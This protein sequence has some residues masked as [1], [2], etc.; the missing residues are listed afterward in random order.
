[1]IPKARAFVTPAREAAH[2]AVETALLGAGFVQA[3][4]AGWRWPPRTPRQEPAFAR[5]IAMGAIRHVIAI[6]TL[7]QRVGEYDPRRVPPDL[8]SILLVAGFQLLWLPS[9]PVFAAVDQAVAAAHRRRGPKAAGMLNALLRRLSDAIDVRHG[10][11]T[12]GNSRALRTDWNAAC[13]FR[14]DVLPTPDEQDGVP[15]LAASSGERA[16][17]VAA[18]IQRHGRPATEAVLWAQQARPPVFLHRNPRRCDHRAFAAAARE[19]Q[20]LSPDMAVY[21][22]GASWAAAELAATGGAYVQDPTARE[23]ALFLQPVAG[24]RVLDLCAAPGGKSFAL[25]L[26]GCAHV[27]ACDLD[28]Q[29]LSQLRVTA[30]RM[31]LP[32]IAPLQLSGNDSRILPTDVDAALVD[33]PCSNSGVFARRPEAR[34]GLT[35][36]KLTAL[37]GLQHHLLGLGAGCVRPGGRLVYSTCS[38]EPQENE[39]LVRQWLNT[40]AGWEIAAERLSLPTAG[41]S[42]ADWRDGGYCVRLVRVR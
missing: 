8:R 11:W 33:A 1:M 18:L 7:L 26:A 22:A 4:L 27:T 13:T 12:Q 39:E 38:I 2:Q 9:V 6:E 32:E 14:R 37:V 16:S 34:L 42:A 31:Q 24:E 20:L 29:R 10:A 3:V 35:R 36:E 5:E 23:A 40:N 30:E 25:A 17:R 21:S 41:E 15:F 19:G 28:G